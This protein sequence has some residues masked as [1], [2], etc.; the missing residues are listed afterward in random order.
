MKNMGTVDR[1]IRMLVGLALI[2]AGVVLQI[3]SGAFWWLALI[4]AIP[5]ITASI[6]T[7]PLYLPFGINTMGKK[8]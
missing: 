5:V 6:S 4:G 7:C 1:T 2:I 3:T 8:K